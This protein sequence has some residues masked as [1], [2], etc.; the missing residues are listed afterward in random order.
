MTKRA[1]SGSPLRILVAS[2][3]SDQARLALTATVDF[4]WPD[5]AEV[6]AVVV[7][8]R[9][10][11]YSPAVEA[12]MQRGAD[13]TA[14]EARRSLAKRWQYARA[15]V[16]RA[17]PVKGVLDEA[18]R[19]GADV[20]VTG[21]R[22]HGSVR[23]ILNGSVSRNVIRQAT[24]SVLV[25][26]R[27]MHCPR[28]IVLG[29]DGSVEAQQAVHL[30]SRLSPKAGHV[31]IVRVADQVPVPHNALVSKKI[32]A[33]VREEVTRINA[34]KSGQERSETKR[35]AEVLRSAGWNVRTVFKTGAPLNA[36]RTAM[37]ESR[38]DLLV[39]GARGT[40]GLRQMLLGS[41]AEGM[42]SECPVSILIA[43]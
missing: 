22:G 11:T 10:S 27:Q 4:P 29:F 39:I 31:T 6:C 40:S 35:A 18:K 30:L 3:G 7:Q 26:R 33:M 15:V 20:I 17:S 28:E 5:S 41:V 1:S 16:A 38:A 13:L 19:F 32:M 8:Q 37:Q 12:A 21:W 2:D 23:R 43:R 14:E 42:L 25:V 36:L 34:E 24:C 9:G